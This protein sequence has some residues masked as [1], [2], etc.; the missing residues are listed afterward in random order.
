MSCCCVVFCVVVCCCV[1]VV[2]CDCLSFV[3]VVRVVFVAV[4]VV[5]VGG[6]VVGLDHFAPDPPLDPPLPDLPK[7]RAS[8]RGILVVL[9]KARTPRLGSR[10]VWCETQRL[11]GHPGLT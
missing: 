11:W 4:V 10:A 2:S 1:F 9:L 6:V 8:S 3:V 7:F 5:R